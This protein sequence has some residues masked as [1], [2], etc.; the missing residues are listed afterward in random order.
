VLWAEY[1]RERE[2]HDGKK[3]MEKKSEDT[4]AK[5]EV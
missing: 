5:R 2:S 3:K 1:L 4:E